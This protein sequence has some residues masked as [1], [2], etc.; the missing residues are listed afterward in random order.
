MSFTVAGETTAWLAIGFEGS[1][2]DVARLTEVEVE[3][4]DALAYLRI[5][6][7]R[8]LYE[9]AIYHD[10][11]RGDKVK[12]GRLDTSAGLN[13]V[14]RYVDGDTILEVLIPSE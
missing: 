10:S 5:K 6:G 2:D 11:T 8:A 3:W 14:Y 13:P 4:T 1:P 9:D 7:G 12:L